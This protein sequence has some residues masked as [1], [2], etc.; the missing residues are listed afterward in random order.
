LGLEQATEPELLAGERVLRTRAEGLSDD[1]SRHAAGLVPAWRRVTAGELRW[2]VSLVVATVIILQVLRPQ[3][4]V[5]ANRWLLPG[6]ETALAVVLLVSDPPRITRSSPAARVIGL[7]LL[8]IA[9]LA[10]GWSAAVLVVGLLDGTA[11]EASDAT[12]LLVNGGSIWLTNVIISGL[13]Y[14]ELDAGGPAAR[15][16]MMKSTRDF[17][18]PEMTAPGLVD[19]SWEPRLLD[20]LYVAFT[21]ATAF[22]PTDTLPLSRRAKLAMMLQAS[23]SVITGVLIIARA[24]NILR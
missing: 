21:N 15:A 20:Y 12:A 2:P 24:V 10:N 13:W 23:V 14:W 6:V 16:G 1:L 3:H 9:S 17:L 8:A 18:F 5:M 11:P 4:L 19:A 22:S 7:V